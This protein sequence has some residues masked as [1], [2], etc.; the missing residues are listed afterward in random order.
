[1][2][3]DTAHITDAAISPPLHREGGEQEKVQGRELDFDENNENWSEHGDKILVDN[4]TGLEDEMEEEIETE[5]KM[6]DSDPIRELCMKMWTDIKSMKEMATAVDSIS[7]N[8]A[9]MKGETAT[10]ADSEPDMA[11]E[12]E[13]RTKINPTREDAQPVRAV[14]V[15]AYQISDRKFV[16]V[17]RKQR[18]RKEQTDCKAS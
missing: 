3:C 9:S 13:T 16:K 14:R 8:V 18:K 5:T 4:V 2:E 7:A 10:T 12:F 15:P 17:E 11:N 6:H 1:M